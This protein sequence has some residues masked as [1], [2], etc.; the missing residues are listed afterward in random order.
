M[1]QIESTK[2]IRCYMIFTIQKKGT[3]CLVL[4]IIF[5]L[6]AT[7]IAVLTYK[8]ARYTI[9]QPLR[10]EVIKRQADLLIEIMEAFSDDDQLLL[11]LGKR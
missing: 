4:W 5:T 9:L 11:D 10:S 6:I 8:R 2:A 7:V 1:L 3:W